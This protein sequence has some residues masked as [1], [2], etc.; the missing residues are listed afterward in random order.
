MQ[1]KRASL[2][3]TVVTTERNY[4][5]RLKVSTEIEFVIKQIEIKMLQVFIQMR[6]ELKKAKKNRKQQ[7]Q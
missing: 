5:R 4:Q 6:V 1:K 3:S 2:Q 7:Q